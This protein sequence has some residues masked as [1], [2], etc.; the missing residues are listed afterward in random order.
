MNQSLLVLLHEAVHATQIC[1]DG[2]RTLPT[3]NRQSRSVVESRLA[4]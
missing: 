3:L 2:R 1:P 4:R